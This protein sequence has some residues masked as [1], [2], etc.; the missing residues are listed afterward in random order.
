M[1]EIG[2]EAGRSFK[3]LVPESH[4]GLRDLV[5]LRPALRALRIDDYRG[6]NGVRGVPELHDALGRKDRFKVHPKASWTIRALSSGYTVNTHDGPYPLIA[7]ALEAF[8][9][10]AVQTQQQEENLNYQET[11]DGRSYISALP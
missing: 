7:E 6:G 5:G 4:Y 11:K 8:V 10:R 3:T 2:L 1:K 9:A